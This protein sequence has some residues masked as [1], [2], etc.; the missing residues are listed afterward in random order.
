MK[1]IYTAISD[2]GHTKDKPITGTLSKGSYEETVIINYKDIPHSI[3]DSTLR[4][5]TE[6]EEIQYLFS[7]SKGRTP[8]QI[9]DSRE[10]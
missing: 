5:A 6:E 3:I 4:E 2:C 10:I 7:A 9:N 1:K 8:E